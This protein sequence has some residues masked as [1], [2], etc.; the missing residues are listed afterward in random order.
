MKTGRLQS[1]TCSNHGCT[2]YDMGVSGKIT[3]SQFWFPYLQNGDRNLKGQNSGADH[4]EIKVRTSLTMFVSEVQRQKKK[5]G[6]LLSAKYYIKGWE[7]N[8][9]IMVAV[10]INKCLW[11]SFFLR[12]SNNNSWV[13][14]KIKL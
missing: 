1:Q 5:L 10:F 12:K 3:F 14:I 4:E 13:R 2:T 6:Y 9:N 7:Y 11:N 8:G